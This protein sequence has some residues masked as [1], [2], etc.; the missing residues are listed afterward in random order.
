[1]CNEI[2]LLQRDFESAF[3]NLIHL[4]KNIIRTVK[5]HSILTTNLIDT[6]ID[7]SVLV[8]SLHSSI[9]NYETVMKNRDGQNIYV[10]K[11]MNLRIMTMQLKFISPIDSI[12]IDHVIDFI[13]NSMLLHRFVIIVTRLN[14]Q[15]RNALYVIK[16][17]LIHES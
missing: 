17:M 9:I 8:N 10:Q 1:M 7:T 13:V 16:K 5:N 2:D 12:V 6:M 14:D 4:R 15:S 11:K 3:Q